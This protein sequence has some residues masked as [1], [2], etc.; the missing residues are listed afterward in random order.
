MAEEVLA[1]FRGLLEKAS[2][3]KTDMKALEKSLSDVT[4]EMMSVLHDKGAFAL[5]AQSLTMDGRW[6]VASRIIQRLAQERRGREYFWRY[7]VLHSLSQLLLDNFQTAK[8]DKQLDKATGIARS[9]ALVAWDSPDAT[10]TSANSLDSI[11]SEFAEGIKAA[12]EKCCHK[13]NTTEA[14]SALNVYLALYY[15]SSGTGMAAT[16]ARLMVCV[17]ACIS[18]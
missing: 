3:S 1:S 2:L 13:G 16:I 6:D 5:L 7:K 17:C 9:L 8:G 4:P 15:A 18:L 12:L 11:W 10:G 14:Y